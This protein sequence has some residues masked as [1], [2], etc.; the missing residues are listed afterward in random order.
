[1]LNMNLTKS[2]SFNTVGCNLTNSSFISQQLVLTVDYEQNIEGNSAK[3][4][5]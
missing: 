2:V 5:V 3:M 4:L 1:M